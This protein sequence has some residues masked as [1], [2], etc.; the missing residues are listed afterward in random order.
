MRDENGRFI[1]GHSYLA[2]GKTLFKKGYKP[3][4]KGGKMSLE[5]RQKLKIAWVKR[6]MNGQGQPNWRG[7]LTSISK[8]IRNSDEYAQWRLAV[9]ERDNYTCQDCG[10]IG[11]RLVADHIKSFANFPELRFDINNGRTLCEDCHYLTDNF[12]YKAAMNRYV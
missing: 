9:F 10:K 2:T 11:G 1:K 12:G 8:K 6:K 5:Q 4:N 3:W 7:G